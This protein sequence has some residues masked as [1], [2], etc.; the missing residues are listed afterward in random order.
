[1]AGLLRQEAGALPWGA[2]V[3]LI[4]AIAPDA[5]RASLLRVREGG[6]PTIWLFLGAA[7]LILPAWL[8]T[9][10]GL[11][12]YL[13]PLLL[14][15]LLVLLRPRRTRVEADGAEERE[16]VWSWQT[17][18]QDLRA[19]WGQLQQRLARPE[20]D[21]LAALAWLRGAASNLA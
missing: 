9:F 16:S 12:P 4:S 10:I 1:M 11:L 20:R 7:S 6:H 13:V 8:T 19:W 21:A 2:T 14:L 15:V 18:G 3:L 17:A 5:L